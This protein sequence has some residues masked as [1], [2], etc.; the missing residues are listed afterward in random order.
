MRPF[1]L[2]ES[3]GVP[4]NRS[5]FNATLGEL[6]EQAGPAGSQTLSL[7]LVDGTTLEVCKIER[8]DDGYMTLRAKRAG[9]E[10]CELSIQGI[11]YSIIYRLE[12]APKQADDKRVGFSWTPRVPGHKGARGR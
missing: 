3:G 4:F 8:L 6:L 9:E 7:Y 1:L 11:P 2:G 12:I 5:F 10:D